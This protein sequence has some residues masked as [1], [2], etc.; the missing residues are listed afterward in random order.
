MKM[1]QTKQAIKKLKALVASPSSDIDKFRDDIEEIFA[2]PLLPNKV[3]IDHAVINDIECDILVP[4]VSSTSQVILYVHGGSFI[5]GSPASWR[6]FC[7]SLAHAS[8]TKLILPK[9]RL[10]PQHPYPAG[11]DDIKAVIKKLYSE[12]KKIILVAD[13]AGAS[14]ALG[15]LL[16][17]KGAFRKKISSVILFSPWLN[18]SDEL[19]NPTA[20]KPPKDKVVTSQALKWSAEM[21]TYS[22]NLKSPF[23]SPVFAE[24]SML[25][26]FPPLYIQV[27]AGELIEADVVYFQGRLRKFGIPCEVDKWKGMVHMFQRADEFFEEAHLAVEKAGNYIREKE[28]IQ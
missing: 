21:Y 25:E 5:G 18:V 20:M 10:A 7:A 1:Q 4:E 16:K 17:I 2:S 6:G 28:E 13:G 19:E 11:L 8:C 27:A 9:Y 26:H 22:E 23:V 12:S 14:I 24:Q 15:V 3:E